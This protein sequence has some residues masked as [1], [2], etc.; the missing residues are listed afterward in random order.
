MKD[1][2]IWFLPFAT[3]FLYLMIILAGAI[4]GTSHA[5][6]EEPVIFTLLG[7]LTG[8]IVATVLCG[9]IFLFLGIDDNLKKILKELT[10]ARSRESR[11]NQ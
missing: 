4:V 2:T 8:F 10:E 5:T 6:T 11:E 1:F 3:I 7:G 9:P